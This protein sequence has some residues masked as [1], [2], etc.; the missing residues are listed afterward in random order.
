LG[1]RLDTGAN[2]AVILAVLVFG[3]LTVRDRVFRHRTD[4]VAVLRVGDKIAVPP[5]YD[6]T[7]YP[8]TLLLALR[9]DCPFCEKSVPF[10]RR[11][12]A[13]EKENRSIA[14]LLAVVSSDAATTREWAASRRL[15][16]QLHP[17]TDFAKIRVQ[18]TPTLVL[19]DPDGRVRKVWAGQL[20]AGEEAE[21]LTQLER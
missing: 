15:D 19:I 3:G 4:G 2:V 13:R 6:S 14:H 11:L 20:T 8:A 12:A 9:P 21:V 18:G 5:G 1:K 17:D 16:M 10:Y 7:K